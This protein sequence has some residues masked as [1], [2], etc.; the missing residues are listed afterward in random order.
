MNWLIGAIGKLFDLMIGLLGGS[1]FWVMLIVSVFTSVWALLMFKAV[2]P[3]ASLTAGRDKLF[4]HIYE[5]GLYQDHLAVVSRIQKDLAR[6]NI[7]YLG[8]TLPSLVILG[9]PMLFTLTQLDSLYKYRPFEPGETTVFSV[10]LAEELAGGLDGLALETDSGVTMEAGPVRD[11]IS[12]SA[13]WRLRA[14]VQGT[15]RLRI[16]AGETELGVRDMVVGN[17]LVRLGET[18]N[19]SWWNAVLHPGA[20]PLPGDGPLNETTLLLP[21]RQSNSLTLGMPWLVLFCILA[22]VA[23]LAL[24]D[25]LRVSI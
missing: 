22:M 16:M 11:E 2:T 12:R 24:K 21:E 17:E 20:P 8:L 6:A 13:A 18:S 15:H 14:E 9:I 25:W 19:K 3:Q 23:G 5:M 1:S 10:T 4:G 7:R